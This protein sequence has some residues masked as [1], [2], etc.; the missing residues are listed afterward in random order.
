MSSTEFI[1]KNFL[2][3]DEQKEIK[4]ALKKNIIPLKFCYINEG[5]DQWDKL[6]GK[7][8]GNTGY[9]S[10]LGDREKAGLS[11]TLSKIPKINYPLNIIH[12]GI[13]NGIEIPIIFNHFDL[14]KSY[15]F[16]VDISY[17]LILK[18]MEN[19]K[20][21]L[22]KMKKAF[23]IVSDVEKE[24][25]LTKICNYARKEGYSR[26]F[27]IFS[28]EGTL[29]SNFSVFKF[30]AKSL[31]ERDFVL[32]SLEGYNKSKEKE[33]LSV[34]NL[35]VSH[36]FLKVGLK[37]AGITKGYFLPAEFNK[38]SWKVEVYFKTFTGRKIL[39][40]RSY[41]PPSKEQFRQILL[42]Y[43]LNPTVIEYHSKLN[44]YGAICK[45]ETG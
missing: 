33:M 1:I 39:C 31:G 12:I 23:F 4:E 3:L 21:F 13:G 40:L 44:M 17:Q 45:R 42:R 38:E 43:G 32:I 30:I 36:E 41:K 20:S 19:Q 28:G 8:E 25:S 10:E 14:K 26:N 18:T 6:R 29:L 15:Y 7:G 37:K 2:N 27:L 11:L 16:G 5:A 9:N 24:N 22:E 34:Y 35:K